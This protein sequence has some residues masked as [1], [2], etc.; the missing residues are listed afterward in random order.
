[1]LD[2]LQRQ[3]RA[4]VDHLPEGEDFALAGGGALV[5]RGVITRPTRD[6]DYFGTS[7]SGVAQLADALE[8]RLAALGFI[9]ERLQS[10]PGFARFRVST[11]EDSTT[12]DLGWDARL[13]SPERAGGGLVLSEAE[14]AA[15]KMLAVADRSAPRDYIDL[16]ALVER[17]GFWKAYS[18]AVEKQ[19]GLD[20]RQLLYAFRYFGDLDRVRFQIPDAGYA[21]LQDTVDGWRRDLTQRLQGPESD[22]RLAPVGG[23]PSDLA[24]P[25]RLEFRPAADDTGCQTTNPIS[26]SVR[27]HRAADKGWELLIRGVAG[28]PLWVSDPY[29]TKE[30]TEGARNFALRVVN[31]KHP[32]RFEGWNPAGPLRSSYV[33]PP[34]EQAST[35][36]RVLPPPQPSGVWRL[37]A[38]R[39]DGSAII[40]SLPYRDATEARAALAFVGVLH[41][42]AGDTTRTGQVRGATQ[43]SDQICDCQTLGT[44][45]RHHEVELPDRRGPDPEYRGPSLGL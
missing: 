36:V 32:L 27:P 19:P 24:G 4:I 43:P 8:A 30:E 38:T 5:V 29:P 22:M 1:M 12:V 13:L 7:Q 23:P 39:P 17:R 15:D 26:V 40:T 37:Q 45:C 35:T 28:S 2:P 6:L 3:L 11:T 9:V 18:T 42:F 44:D 41:L 16:A 34:H 21:Q 33:P 25:P 14:L 31:G 20:P 10:L